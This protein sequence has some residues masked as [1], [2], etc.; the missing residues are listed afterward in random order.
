MGVV[1]C[2]GKSNRM[3]QDKGLITT[4]NKTWAEIAYEKLATLS[5]PVCVS[6]NTSQLEKYRA[7][8][9]EDTLVTDS[10]PIE[11][12]LCG[13]LSAHNAFPYHDLIILACDMIEVTPTLVMQ[14]S[15]KLRQHEG[16][17]DFFVFQHHDT[18]EPL[19]GIYT[20]EGLQK[21]TDL[22]MLG[23][24]EKWSMKYVLE[25][26]NTLVIETNIAEEISQLKNYNTPQDII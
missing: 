16:E 24:L 6:I 17:H 2:G 19:L 20:R 15:D 11:G 12:P 9:E 18:L 25:N 8:F 3:G 10:F 26:G 7:I 21:L 1:F 14:L 13:L 23:Q 5:I 4:D 22:F